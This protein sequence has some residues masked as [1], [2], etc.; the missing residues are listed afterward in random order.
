MKIIFNEHNKYKLKYIKYL[1][2]EVSQTTEI[3]SMTYI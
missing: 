3:N 1:Q 2:D